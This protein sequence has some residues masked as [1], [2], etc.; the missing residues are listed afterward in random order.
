VV[1]ILS[2]ESIVSRVVVF[3]AVFLSLAACGP[4][5]G[6]GGFAPDFKTSPSF[7]TRMSRPIDN[8]GMDA[9][10]FVHKLQRTWYSAN[11]RQ[12]LG[13]DDLP[14]GTVAIK[15]TYD[16]MG[17]P[18]AVYVMVKRAKGTWNYEARGKDGA[19]LPGAP[20]GDNVPMCHGCHAKF[21]STD[22][23]GGTAYND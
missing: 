19:E 1:F 16:A 5:D 23:L 22:Y 12:S 18:A 2:R 14:V 13:G 7:F 6:P 4:A 21:A 8:S 17:Q 10:T 15:E 9:A 3:S 20:R 11:A